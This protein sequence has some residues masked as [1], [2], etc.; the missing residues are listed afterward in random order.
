MS[1]TWNNK[2]AG[3]SSG[4]SIWGRK[5]GAGGT[6][7]ASGAGAS[8]LPMKKED[9][10]PI[11]AWI[12]QEPKK[13]DA[14]KPK[15][16]AGYV[17]PNKREAPKQTFEEAFPTLGGGP[18]AAKSIEGAMKF[19][20]MAKTRVEK[21]ATIAETLKK[22]EAARVAR[23]KANSIHQYAVGPNFARYHEAVRQREA[24]AAYRR[25]R[26]FDDE[27]DEEWE[28]ETPEEDSDEL[29]NR[30]DEVEG[31]EEVDGYDASAFD[32]HR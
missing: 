19:G 5:Y 10:T 14:E 11:C 6:G 17:P 21:D 15:G 13:T 20:D 26:I 18:A 29:E 3:G 7:G 27:T 16:S 1:N 25:R 32:R 30:S 24:E 23:S 9:T 8:P 31:E 12:C 22:E 4:G 2:S 28:E